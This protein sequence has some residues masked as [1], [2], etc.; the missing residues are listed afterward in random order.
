MCKICIKENLIFSFSSRKRKKIVCHGASKKKNVAP[1][2]HSEKALEAE[3]VNRK[4]LYV[5]ISIKK[6]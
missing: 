3:R 2:I 4:V 1:K 5:S 6:A